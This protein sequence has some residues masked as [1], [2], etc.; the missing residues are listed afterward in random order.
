ME[1]TVAFAAFPITTMNK[2]N[3][4]EIKQV[5]LW[6]AEGRIGECYP[7][8]FVN[9]NIEGNSFKY[10]GQWKETKDAGG[11]ETLVGCMSKDIRGDV[12]K[13]MAHWGKTAPKMG[14]NKT[15]FHVMFTNGFNYGGRFDMSAGGLDAGEHFFKSLRSRMEFFMKQKNQPWG[16][17]AQE[18]K[19]Y[20]KAI[21]ETLDGW[22]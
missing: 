18:W 6:R 9:E 8:I 10:H 1:L 11:G 16:V 19:D 7:I 13:H 2:L 12:L 21:G 17:D 4:V 14:Y 5:S 15:D 22:N 3:M 20:Q